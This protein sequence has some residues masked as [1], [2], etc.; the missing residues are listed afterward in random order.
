M[1]NNA[2]QMEPPLK[3]FHI[4]FYTFPAILTCFKYCIYIYFTYET[5]LEVWE[6]S[7]TLI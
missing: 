4:C 3:N 5:L 7:F 1:I 2:C 6:V